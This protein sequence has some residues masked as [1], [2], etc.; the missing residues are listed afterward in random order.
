MT[1]TVESRSLPDE[2]ARE[3]VPGGWK[4]VHEVTEVSKSTVNGMSWNAIKL[5]RCM[6]MP[7]GTGLKRDQ[8]KQGLTRHGK[9]FELHAKDQCEAIKDFNQRKDIISV[10]FLKFTLYC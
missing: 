10:R 7:W 1:P 9:E 3:G 6:W 2:D 4:S 5:E 8:I